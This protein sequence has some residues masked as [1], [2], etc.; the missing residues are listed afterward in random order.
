MKCME[1]NGQWQR[2]WFS[3]SKK[4]LFITSN[5]L[6]IIHDTATS[7]PPTHQYPLHPRY[8]SKCLDELLENLFIIKIQKSIKIN[9]GSP[10]ADKLMDAVKSTVR[11]GGW[12]W[13]GDGKTGWKEKLKFNQWKIFIYYFCG[14]DSSIKS[15]LAMSDCWSR[16]PCISGR[17]TCI[18]R[19]QKGW[20]LL[21]ENI[22]VEKPNCKQTKWKYCYYFIH[23]NFHYLT[24]ISLSPSDN[25]ISNSV[26]IVFTN[27]WH[28]HS[29]PYN[30]M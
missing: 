28:F 8:I 19:S 17:V 18:I 27:M 15:L 14:N 30:C 20:W 21:K 1:V 12:A 25:R 11:M 2:N 29:F 16:A 3:L 5:V 9:S 13:D 24:W 22:F 26:C 10:I 23:F 6:Q 7:Q 4:L